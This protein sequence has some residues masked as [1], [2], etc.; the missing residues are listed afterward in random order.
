M[1]NFDCRVIFYLIKYFTNLITKM[2][3]P[4]GRG[5]NPIGKVTG[6][7]LNPSKRSNVRVRLDDVPSGRVIKQLEKRLHD[8]PPHD[9]E[10]E[11]IFNKSRKFVSKFPCSNVQMEN[12][13]QVSFAFL[14]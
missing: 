12:L 1:I 9:C 10:L 14:V 11:T 2:P 5:K 3:F 4:Y 6:K 13:V 8:E 7:V